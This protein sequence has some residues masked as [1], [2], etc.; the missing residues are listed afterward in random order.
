MSAEATDKHT[1]SEVL[2]MAVSQLNITDRV[3]LFMSLNYC[4]PQFS[5]YKLLLYKF[6]KI[7]LKV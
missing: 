4:G 5:S 2:V 6:V 7:V 1:E 3:I